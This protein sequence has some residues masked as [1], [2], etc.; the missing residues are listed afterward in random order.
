MKKMLIVF[1]SWSNGNTERIAKLLQEATG[2]DMARIETVVPY[3]GSYD[4]IVQQGQEEVERSFE[5][6][7]RPL[8]INIREYDVIAIG[9][10]TWWYTMAPAILTFLHQQDWNGKTVVPFQTHG[11]WPGHV[12]KDIAGSCDGAKIVCGMPVKF[13]S[14]GG[15]HLETKEA[16][17]ESWVQKVK[18]LL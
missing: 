18:A 10:P 2:A 8:S 3:T 7:I 6:E 1:Y 5:P 14:Y 12:L 4:D 15:N 11:G 17:I 9:T 16:E 13:D